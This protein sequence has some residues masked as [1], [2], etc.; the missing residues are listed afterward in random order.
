MIERARLPGLLLRAVLISI[1]AVPNVYL[2]GRSVSLMLG[3]EPAVDWTHY[4]EA[5][6]R[7][8]DGNL[9]VLSESY[10]W[11]Y[12]PIAAYL[13]GV[14]GL[15]GT[16]AWRAMHVVAA[17][18]LPNRWMIGLALV[19][20]PFWWDVQ[21]GNTMIFFLLAAAW[22]I[23][24]NRWATGAYLLGVLLIPRPLFIPVALWLLWK[25][26]EWRIPFI[27]LFAVHAVG[28]LASGWAD[29][30][31]RELLHDPKEVGSLTDVGPTRFIGR[32]WL[33][34]GIPLGIWLTV[35]GRLGWA[36]L[37]ISPYLLP[38]YLLFGLLELVPKPRSAN[39]S[40]GLKSQATRDGDELEGAAIPISSS[41][42]S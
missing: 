9:Y 39:Q 23:K 24:G 6:R 5:S 12:S 8:V 26:P 35:K 18:S 15:I 20:W 27:A 16:F 30:W 41:V 37:A 40:R 14:I 3:G 31:A 32:A 28:V 21:T 33:V 22:A 42:R 11:R 38:Y 36:S 34:I 7:V 2:V 19:S 10:G 29:E 17:F 1:V 25:R 4:L 13:F